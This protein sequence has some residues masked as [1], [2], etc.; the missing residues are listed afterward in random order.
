[1]PIYG[2]SEKA[3]DIWSSMRLTESE[4]RE[5]PHCWHS[6]GEEWPNK[7]LNRSLELYNNSVN[8]ISDNLS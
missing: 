4:N 2:G 8:I 7:T 5:P 1:M 6:W 3:T